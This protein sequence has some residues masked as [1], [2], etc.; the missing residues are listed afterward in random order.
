MTENTNELRTHNYVFVSSDT[1][2]NPWAPIKQSGVLMMIQWG[3]ST[4]VVNKFTTYHISH[5]TVDMTQGDSVSPCW[6]VRCASPAHH[7]PCNKGRMY[8]QFQPSHW[9]MNT[10]FSFKWKILK[11]NKE[12][13]MSKQKLA[14]DI[15]AVFKQCWMPSPVV[16]SC[17][18]ILN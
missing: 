9:C 3:Q 12:N 13:S 11:Q 10:Q 4:D 7:S 6:K 1:S 16:F 5:Y 14:A 15:Q 18:L 2:S 8:P 17:F